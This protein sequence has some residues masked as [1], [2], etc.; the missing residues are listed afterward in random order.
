MP[1][2]V[3]LDKEKCKRCGTCSKLV[4][5]PSIEESACIGCGACILACPFDAR[6]LEEK[7]RE[8]EITIRIDDN[9]YKVPE[10]ISIK[11]ALTMTGHKNAILPGTQELSTAC[12]IGACMS[13]AIEINDKVMPG[14]VTSVK[15]GMNIKTEL[16][17]DYVPRRRIMFLSG[18]AG[19]PQVEAV[20]FTVGC[21]FICSQC[22]N[23][24]I[25]YNGKAE[26]FTPQ[27]AAH[28]LTM[29]KRMIGVNRTLITGGECTLNRPWL[30]QYLS[31][32]TRLDPDPSSRILVDTNGSLL[33]NSYVDEIVETGA[34]DI[35][36]D[37]KGLQL[38]TFIKITGLKDSHMAERYKRTAWEAVKY[39]SHNY[40]DK[41]SLSVS[42]PYNNELISLSEF[43]DIG[44]RL[45]ESDPSIQVGIISYYGAFKSKN[46]QPP[47]SK[48]M[49]KA[50]R[51][52]RDVGLKNVFAKTMEGFIKPSGEFMPTKG[53]Y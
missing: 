14:C 49:K 6:I 27:E 3:Y 16:P 15:E 11:E 51:I 40:K 24:F 4:N 35:S 26:I 32:L 5:C 20:C 23:S 13:C 33:T 41:I 1:Y 8:R 43:N 7:P 53:P 37:L 39:I 30:I 48:E 47:S 2:S 12:G 21:N 10:R 50:H 28:R 46:M 45:L 25:T 31:E 34:T 19:I 22:I 17:K 52:L 29:T 42:I 18:P 9:S 36:I 44:L 38:D